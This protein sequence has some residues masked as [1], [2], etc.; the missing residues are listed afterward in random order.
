MIHIFILHG[1]GSTPQS[2][3]FPWLR[4]SL[5]KQGHAVYVPRF[6]TPGGQSLENWL[7][8]LSP[9]DERLEGAILIGHSLAPAFILTL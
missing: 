6:P 8:V 7:K 9:E 1:T 3:W 5:Q 2:N 4:E